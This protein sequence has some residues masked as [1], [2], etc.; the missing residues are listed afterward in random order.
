MNR[1]LN[2]N[3]IAECDLN[4]KTAYVVHVLK[5]ID[6]LSKFGNCVKLY[7]P[8]SKKQVLNLKYFYAVNLK[9]CKIFSIIDKPILSFLSRI[10]FCL[11]SAFKVEKNSIIITR[12][13]WSSIFLSILKKK[14]YLEI[15]N[16]VRGLT[17]LFIINLGFIYS[18]Q[19]IKLIFISKSLAKIYKIN[20]KF[21]QLHDA[22]D[23]EHFKFK[24]KKYKKIINIGYIG[25]FFKGRGIRK[26]LL[27]SSK[28]KKYQS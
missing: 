26:I 11:I 9:N 8:N 21:L 1:N 6:N 20:K 19:I 2:I 14:H 27:M 16:E 15:H 22:V 10:I 18:G 13:F 23:L 4:S 25:S 5:M 7:V 24:P 17:K 12:S 3:Y 28:L